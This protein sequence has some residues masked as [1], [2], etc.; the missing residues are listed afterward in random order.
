VLETKA[1]FNETT[2]GY[3]YVPAG[4]Y[5]M[6]IVDYDVYTMKDGNSMVFNLK[7]RIADEVKKLEVEKI[8]KNGD[9]QMTTVDDEEGNPIRVSAKFLAGKEYQNKG[10][11]LTANPAEGEGWKNRAYKTFCENLGIEFPKDEDGNIQLMQ[12]E[13][14]DVIGLPCLGNLQSVTF[15]NDAGEEISIMKVVE[16]FPWAS[17]QKLPAEEIGEEVPF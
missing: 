5:P 8:V 6:H 4:S 13:E 11:W 9:G 12:I 15:E 10:V 3:T 17:G 16:V 2:D 14:E 7:F 1:T